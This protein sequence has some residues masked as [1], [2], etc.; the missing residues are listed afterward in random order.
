M[1]GESGIDVRPATDKQVAQDNLAP[2]TLLVRDFSFKAGGST[3]AVKAQP[4]GTLVG[5]RDGEA[6]KTW[7]SI[8]ASPAPSSNGAAA[9]LSTL[10]SMLAS[11]PLGDAGRSGLMQLTA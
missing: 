4:D 3:Y 6:W 10:Q 9:A 5:T 11:R 1:F 8:P 2:G 7:K